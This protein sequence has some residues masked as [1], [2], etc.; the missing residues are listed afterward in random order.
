[1]GHQLSDDAKA[2]RTFLLS[3]SRWFLC[4]IVL[5]VLLLLDIGFYQTLRSDFKSKISEA[6]ILVLLLACGSLAIRSRK[7]LLK[8]L[9]STDAIVCVRCVYPLSDLPVQGQ[10]PECGRLYDHDVT[11]AAWHHTMRRFNCLRDDKHS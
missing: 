3:G 7:R 10:C 9:R 11:R 6:I 4:S 2:K 8:H 1:M 5:A